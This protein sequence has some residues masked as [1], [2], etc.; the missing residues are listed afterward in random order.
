MKSIK[1]FVTTGK[2]PLER[3]WWQS[4]L[5]LRY[6]VNQ[7]L[8]KTKGN[9][10]NDGEQIWCWAEIIIIVVTVVAVFVE[11]PKIYSGTDIMLFNFLNFL[12]CSHNTLLQPLTT[13]LSLLVGRWPYSCFPS[14]YFPLSCSILE[15]YSAFILGAACTLC[16]RE[17]NVLEK[18]R[19]V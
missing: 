13:T 12:L 19:V 3:E 18:G 17:N 8:K 2:E 9:K 10:M 14:S 7:H 5:I 15:N 4:V 16:R 11:L 1:H 6:N